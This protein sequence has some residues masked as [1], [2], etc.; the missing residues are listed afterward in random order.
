MAPEHG[1]K[2]CDSASGV[3][4]SH[5]VVQAESACVDTSGRVSLVTLNDDPVAYS[6]LDKIEQESSYKRR[7]LKDRLEAFIVIEMESEPSKLVSRQLMLHL[8]EH[9]RRSQLNA[10]AE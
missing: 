3:G 1:T 6:D 5:S 2:Q 9:V 7:E 10:N 8:E 4:T